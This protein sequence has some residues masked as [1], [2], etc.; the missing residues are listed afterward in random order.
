ME[1]IKNK[2]CCTCKK[3]PGEIELNDSEEEPVEGNVLEVV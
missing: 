3:L 2:S 1:T